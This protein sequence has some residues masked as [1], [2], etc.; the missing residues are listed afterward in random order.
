MRSALTGSGSSAAT[1]SPSSAPTGRGS[2]GRS[3]P[4][5]CSAPSRCRSTPT[6]S[7]RSS[8]IVLAHAECASRR[9]RTRSRSTRSCRSR[10]GCRSSSRWSTTRRAACATTT[11]AHLHAM[12]DV[13]ADGRKALADP[14]SAP[15]SM[16]EI[17][18]GKGSD[19][20]IILYTSGT[21]GT[22]KGVVLTGERCDQGGRRHRRLRQ[23][24]REGRGARLSAARLGRRSLP[25]LRARPG[26]RL[27]HGLP[28]ERRHRDGRICARSGR[29]SI[30]RRR[31]CSRCCSRA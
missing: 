25:Q 21:T 14:A 2:I 28:G 12:D 20:S 10:S 29:A 1:P 18:A 17:A 22:S 19:P 24:D 4:R 27:L 31:A 15:G 13:I 23:A 8:P 30:S 16:R 11:T 9:S 7:P 3:W 26:R 6:R 5:R